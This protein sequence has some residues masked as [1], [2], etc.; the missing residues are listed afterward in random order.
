MEKYSETRSQWKIFREINPLVK[1]LIWRKNVDFRVKIVI[2]FC[3]VLF[4]KLWNYCMVISRI[5]LQVRTM[6]QN[7]SNINSELKILLTKEKTAKFAFLQ[8]W[9]HKAITKTISFRHGNQCSCSPINVSEIIL[10]FG[11]N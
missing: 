11:Y 8:F 7:F 10:T 4:L 6:L 1:T 3:K 5:I 9:G 2:A